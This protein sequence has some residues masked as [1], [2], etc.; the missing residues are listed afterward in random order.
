V[1]ENARGRVERRGAALLPPPKGYMTRDARADAVLSRDRFFVRN[2][3]T[4]SNGASD[5]RARLR[6]DA[7]SSFPFNPQNL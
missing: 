1:N 3:P 5:F 4:R 6:Y 7:P 2:P